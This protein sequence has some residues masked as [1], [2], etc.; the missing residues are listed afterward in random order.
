MAVA[1]FP[2][3]VLSPN[4]NNIK[5]KTMNATCSELS[6]HHFNLQKIIPPRLI[7]KLTDR[8]V[9]FRIYDP[10]TTLHCFLYQV[11]HQASCKAAVSGLNIQRIKAG[12]KSISMNTA[13][14]T[15][16][17]RRLCENTL[18]KI[19]KAIGEE[20]DQTGN[21][22]WK[23]K[24]VF[25]VD[26]T[27]L[28]LEDT[29]KNKSRYPQAVIKGKPVG[30]PKLRMLGVFSLFSGSFLDAELGSYSGKGQGEPTLIKKIIPRFKK[31]SILVLDRFFT[32]FKLQNLFLQAKLE[33][34]IRAR[35][36]FAKKVLHGRS[37]VVV[38]MRT[39]NS[40]I[41]VPVSECN[42]QNGLQV[43]VIKSSI[44]RKGFRVATIYIM[45]SLLDSKLYQKNEIEELY[46][47][48]WCIELDI[49]HLKVTLNASLLR[50]KSPSIIRKE[51][52]VHL[53]GFNI[54]RKIAGMTSLKYKLALPRAISFKTTL[55]VFLQAIMVFGAKKG[56]EIIFDLLRK[57]I[58]KSPYRRE[59]RAIKKRHNRYPFLTCSR[60][61]SKNEGWGYVRRHGQK[62]LC[63][64]GAA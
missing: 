19:A 26:G 35:D 25:L 43:R 27:V 62:G 64:I 42:V 40:G 56:P 5:G 59:P 28:N 36:I 3:N 23:G 8:C 45:T 20:N 32:S 22:K 10:V 16:A 47:K 11:L 37:D 51:L 44:K 30:Q 9:R 58:L 60:K 49:R 38:T 7:K 54:V 33:Y 53:I 15:K 14:L 21:W 34:V 4:T 50:S 13:A 61:T 24:E 18:F 63:A 46:L 6:G 55:R 2:D 12:L 57:E 48:R 29:K 1:D 41:Y 17:K 31:G 52:W 39:T